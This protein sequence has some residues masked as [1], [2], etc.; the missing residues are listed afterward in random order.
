MKCPA[1]NAPVVSES[2]EGGAVMYCNQCGWGKDRAYQA[3]QHG[4]DED[5]EPVKPPLLLVLLGLVFSALL[6]VG[7]Y[8]A[9]LHYVPSV[10]AWMHLTYWLTMTAYLFFSITVTPSY[11]TSNLGLFGTMIDNPFSFADDMNRWGLMLSILFLPGKAVGWSVR[12]A[13]RW[14]KG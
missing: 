2:V 8:G 4:I 3:R 12:G 13:A 10:A 1:C 5:P 11:D 14:V 6:I 9:M 7:P